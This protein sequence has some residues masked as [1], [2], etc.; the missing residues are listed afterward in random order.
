M[1]HRRFAMG[2]VCRG[3][4]KRCGTFGHVH[5]PNASIRP[6]HASTGRLNCDVQMRVTRRQPQRGAGLIGIAAIRKGRFKATGPRHIDL[7]FHVIVFL[8]PVFD[9]IPVVMHVAGFYFPVRLTPREVDFHGVLVLAADLDR[10]ALVSLPCSH[11]LEPAQESVTELFGQI[12]F[13]TCEICF[14]ARIFLE[15]IELAVDEFVLAVKD[16]PTLVGRRP[17]TVPLMEQIVVGRSA[18]TGSQQR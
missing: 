9:R 11:L 16:R 1:N 18:L 14:L 10:Y 15:I 12:G 3:D 13:P 7:P 4:G 17:D 8:R 5:G 6:E 2:D